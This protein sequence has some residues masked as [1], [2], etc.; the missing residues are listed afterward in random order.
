MLLSA[1]PILYNNLTIK[2]VAFFKAA[3]VTLYSNV[4]ACNL[5]ILYSFI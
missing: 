2:R 1:L 5:Y 4:L 3:C